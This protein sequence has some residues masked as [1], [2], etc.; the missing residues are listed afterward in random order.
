MSWPTKPDRH[1]AVVII[2]RKNGDYFVHQRLSTKRQY[3]DLFGV[4]AGGSFEP[5]EL[6]EQAALREMREETG[7]S[8]QVTALF[9][10]EYHE[11]GLLHELSVFETITDEAPGHDAS[12]WQWSGWLTPDELGALAKGDKL[13]PD[14]RALLER[15]WARE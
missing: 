6:P 10:L 14:T 7:L 13:C 11:P 5:G 15:Y 2:R 9:S 1:I 4:G 8:G 3:P 12:E